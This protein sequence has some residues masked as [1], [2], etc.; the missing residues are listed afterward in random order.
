MIGFLALWGQRVRRDRVQLPIW[1][2]GAAALAAAADSGVSASYAT[3]AD[4]VS[5][6]ALSLAHPVILLFRGLP[7]GPAEGAFIAFQIMPWLALLAA[8]MS[9]FLAVRH[10]RA[11]EELGRAELV[12]ATA[13]G[14]AVPLA[15]TIAHGLVA[16]IALGGLVSLAFVLPGLPVR[17]SVL[18]GAAAA[19]VGLA[20]LGMGLLAAQLVGSARA[21]NSLSMIVLL[22]TFLLA[23]IGNALGTPS[24]DLLRLRS[25]WLTWLSPFGWAE[26]SRPYDEDT[27]APILLCVALGAALIAVSAALQATRDLGGSLVAVRPARGEARPALASGLALIWRQSSGSVLGW[28]IGGAITGLLSTSLSAVVDQAGGSNPAVAEVLSALAGQ[29]SL[30]EGALT[31]FFIMLGVLAA[32]CAVQTV[33]RARQEET[34]GTAEL[35]LAAPMSRVHWCIDHLIVGFGAIVLIAVA[36][37]AGAGLGLLASRGGADLF[38][39]VLVLSAGQ[40][41]AASV[42]LV[43]TALL[44]VVA[45]RLAVPAGWSLLGLGVML[46]LFGP[47]FGLPGS[48]TRVSPFAAAPV[49]SNGAVQANGVSWLVGVMLIGAAVSI[50]LMRRREIATGGS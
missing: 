45:P 21:A 10:T 37:D 38:R 23:G 43:A 44:F 7:S 32:C 22:V 20:F 9:A 11:D 16:N 5:I 17:G 50:A 4:R 19:S 48:L 13:A 39:D 18:V 49:V 33:A 27:W 34:R 6:L 31:S 3:E 41:I 15:A 8:L 46:G 12:A 36:A 47:L 24:D 26:S 30:A 2:L 28:A 1:I 35:L 40:V 42:F 29:G 25:S 14:R